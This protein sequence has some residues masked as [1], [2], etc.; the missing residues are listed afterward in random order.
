LTDALGNRDT[1]KLWTLY[2]KAIRAGI[3]LEKI[4]GILA[5]QVR[6][7]V[8]VMHDD[9]EGL[10]P[11]VITKAKRFAKQYSEKEIRELSLHLLSLY[12]NAHRGV[13]DFELEMERLI[14]MRV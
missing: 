2:R 3:E 1:G 13:V 6:T 8:R 7:M 12:H 5:W 11:F 4:H 14:L 9:T 10:K